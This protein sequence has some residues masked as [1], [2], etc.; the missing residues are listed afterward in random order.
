LQEE[1]WFIR[2]ISQLGRVLGKILA[3]LLGLKEQGRISEGIDAAKLT[4]LTKVD[5]NIDELADLP[6]ERFIE[7]MKERRQMNN[8]DFEKLADI[9]F[10]ISEE[11]YGT[12]KDAE[13][14]I[15]LSEKALIVFEYLNKA[16]STY[17]LDRQNKIR[18]IKIIM[19]GSSRNG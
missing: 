14:K 13:M 19:N 2:Q 7:I 1:D 8:E 18:E 9:F 3:D 12:A 6:A 11:L 17:S 16:G 4:L 10:L 5:M 15:K